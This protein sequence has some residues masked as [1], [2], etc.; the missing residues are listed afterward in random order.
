MYT[1]YPCLTFLY[2]LRFK[3]ALT[4]LSNMQFQDTIIYGYAFLNSY[5]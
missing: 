1:S 5:Y 4:I 2:Q 3:E